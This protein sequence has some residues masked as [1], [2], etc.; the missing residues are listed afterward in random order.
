M[1]VGIT[2]ADHR[3]GGRMMTALL[4]TGVAVLMTAVAVALGGLALELVLFAISRSLETR[5]ASSTE[6]RGVPAALHLKPSENSKGTM[7]WAEE[8]TA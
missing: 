8:A 4:A 5:A 7:E 6:R 3:N 2:V 1:R